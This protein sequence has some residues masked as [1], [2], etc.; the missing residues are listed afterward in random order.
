[1]GFGQ[2]TFTV[3]QGNGR[4]APKTAIRTTVASDANPVNSRAAGLGN[5]LGADGMAEE[6]WST[7]SHCS[8]FLTKV[9]L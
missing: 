1:M 5:Y 2:G 4:D 9:K 7:M 3:T 6:W 8:P